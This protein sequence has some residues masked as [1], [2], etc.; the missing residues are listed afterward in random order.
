MLENLMQPKWRWSVMVFSLT[1]FKP[2]S[3]TETLMERLRKKL[4]LLE[5]NWTFLNV[6][7]GQNQVPPYNEKP[8][9]SDIHHNREE[10][11]DYCDCHKGLGPRGGNILEDVSTLPGERDVVRPSKHHGSHSGYRV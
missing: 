11:K 4:Q 5:C 6:P 1:L 2:E 3:D 9:H 10:R 8:F 7:V